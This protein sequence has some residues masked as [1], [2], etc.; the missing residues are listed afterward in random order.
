MTI[1]TKRQ[2]MGF[3]EAFNNRAVDSLHS[4]LAPDWRVHPDLPGTTPHLAQYLPV[5]QLLVDAF[6]DLHFEV[7]FLL[8][9]NGIYAVQSVITGTQ[10]ADWL[11]VSPKG[12]Q[13]KIFAHDFHRVSGG[14][15][16]ESWHVEDWLTGVRQMTG[17]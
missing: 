13:I 5:A 9:E 2:V 11:G 7:N 14:Q 15:I 16:A 17:S 3:Y 10:Q 4:V 8:E 1:E 6:P 12:N